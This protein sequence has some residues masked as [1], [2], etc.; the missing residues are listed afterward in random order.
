MKRT[1]G[2]GKRNEP[3]PAPDFGGGS[4]NRR[5]LALDV[6]CAAEADVTVLITG[7]HRLTT[8]VARWIHQNGPRRKGPLLVVDCNR[9]TCPPSIVPGLQ[10]AGDAS[11]P[12]AGGSLDG[13]VLL[14]QEVGAMAPDKLAELLRTVEATRLEKEPGPGPHRPGVRII[15]TSST[16]L[17]S[18]VA[19]GTF[20]EECFYCLNAIHLVVSPDRATGDDA[21]IAG[22]AT[23]GRRAPRN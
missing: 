19:K 8:Q 1:R 13:A 9:A 4:Q 20:P 14:L 7:R 23:R 10:L 15:A 5:E 11:S 17:A 16:D 22:S 12:D 21:P 6:Q 18:D 2:K 3:E